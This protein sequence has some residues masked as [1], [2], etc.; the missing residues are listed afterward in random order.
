MK[1]SRDRRV[2][3]ELKECTFKPSLVSDNA[4]YWNPSD[5]DFLRRCELW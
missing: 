4:R 3:E 5:I 1:P 2:D